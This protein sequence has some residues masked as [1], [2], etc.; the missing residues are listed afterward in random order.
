MKGTIAVALLILVVTGSTGVSQTVGSK[1]AYQQVTSGQQRAQDA[2]L[3]FERAKKITRVKPEPL[4]PGISPDEVHLDPSKLVTGKTGKLDYW[5]TTVIA[6]IDDKNA[7]IEC[8]KSL[9]WL[10][11]FPTQNL[12]TDQEVR[13]IDYVKVGEPKSHNNY[14]MPTISL[15]PLE[16]NE[17]LTADEAKII[18]QKKEAEAKSESAKL[19]DFRVWKSK[20]G[21]ADVEGKFIRFRSPTVE[22]ELKNGRKSTFRITALA[23][24]DAELVRT[25]A[26]EDAE[27]KKDNPK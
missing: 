3:A 15:V 11:D 20:N 19:R 27:S 22:I 23:D 13:I 1:K 18:A 5:K 6:V 9:V 7:V 2:R 24:A 25:L 4:M 8:A 14:R 21:S 16:E 26:K 12:L 10:S 17:R